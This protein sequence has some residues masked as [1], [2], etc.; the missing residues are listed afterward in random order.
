MIETPSSPI[1][2]CVIPEKHKL[3]LGMKNGGIYI[4]DENYEMCNKLE[5]GEEIIH[6]IIWIKVTKALWIGDK[7][8]II[9]WDIENN[10]KVRQYKQLGEIYA[11][12]STQERVFGGGETGILYEFGLQGTSI[13]KII[14][15]IKSIKILHLCEDG[16]A[17]LGLDMGFISIWDLKNRSK[18]N[19]LRCGEDDILQYSLCPVGGDVYMVGTWDNSIRLVN[20]GKK[21]ILKEYPSQYQILAMGKLII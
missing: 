14:K 13:T 6:K 4:Y 12:E 20:L 1:S 5:I 17:V 7:E 9:I 18:I 16:T 19:S 2:I 15:E 21:K 8:G 11:L 3:A 10:R